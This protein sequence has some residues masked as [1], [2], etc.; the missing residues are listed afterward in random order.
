MEIKKYDSK[1]VKEVLN[2]GIIYSLLY[3]TKNG[4][5]YSTSAEE[6]IE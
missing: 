3:C 1:K 4:K 6:Y 5:F 2:E